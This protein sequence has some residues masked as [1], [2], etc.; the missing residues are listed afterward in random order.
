ML[1]KSRYTLMVKELLSLVKTLKEFRTILLD[2][3]FKIC[4]EQINFDVQK[5]QHR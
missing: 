4:T 5:L 3:R 1:E 2:Q